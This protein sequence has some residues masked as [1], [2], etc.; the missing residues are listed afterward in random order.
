MT[1]SFESVEPSARA[2]LVRMFG[3]DARAWL[4]QLPELL[5]T[6]LAN[7]D[8]QLERALPGGLLASTSLVTTRDGV[9]A[10]LKIPS[11][12]GRGDDEL[13]ALRVW[14]GVGAPALLAHDTATGARLLERIA[15]GA[16]AVDAEASQVATTLDR[17]HVS[18]PAG[19]PTLTALVRTRLD[20]AEAQGRAT[21][22]RLT[23]ARAAAERRFTAPHETV[24]VHGDFD[25]RNLLTCARR[26]LCAI[27]PLPCAGD[28]AYDAGYWAQAAGL[29]GRRARVH[30]IAES[31]GLEVERV[32]DWCAVVAVHG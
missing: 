5:A 18:P 29:P 10:V 1:G 23:W 7:L 9:E 32:R 19:L 30:A 2:F 31:L 25:H 8:V 14:K 17:L 24:L 28:R 3:D 20:R 22:E 16:Q 4:A 26:G 21:P 6:A 12:W 13:T 15:P 11:P 27:D